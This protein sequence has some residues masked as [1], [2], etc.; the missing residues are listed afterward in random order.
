MY[1]LH[2]TWTKT[3]KL[4][5]C[6][7]KERGTPKWHKEGDLQRKR[8]QGWKIPFEKKI[9]ILDKN[10]KGGHNFLRGIK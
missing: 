4:I 10:K 5:R 2:A 6:I 9:L 7:I 1:C 3:G 8:K